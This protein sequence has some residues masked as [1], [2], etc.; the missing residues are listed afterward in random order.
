MGIY[1]QDGHVRYDSTGR[2][3]GGTFRT[4]INMLA[5]LKENGFTHIYLMG[6]YQLDKPENIKGQ[7]GPDASLFSPLSWEISRELGR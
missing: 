6:I 2:A 3:V 5:Y 4:A 7:A 1:A